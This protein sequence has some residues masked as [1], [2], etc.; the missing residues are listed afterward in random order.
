MSERRRYSLRP[1]A[2]P[3]PARGVAACV[4]ST[5][6]TTLG[7]DLQGGVQLV[8]EGEPT[9][10]QPT[11]TQEA[12]NRSL[13]IMRDRVDAFGV[14]EPEL[15]AR[16]ATRSRSTCPA[17]TNAERAAQQVGFDRAAVLLRLGS[18]HPRR[19]LQ[20]RPGRSNASEKTPITGLLQGGQAGLQVRRRRSTATTTPPT[21]RGSTRSTRSS[22]KPLNNGQPSESKE[23]GAR[24]DLTPRP[25]A[26][27]EVVEV[28][29]GILVVRDQKRERQRPGPRT[30]GG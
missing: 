17:S 20:D 27:A 8:Y 5:K 23:R 28:P 16:A 29:E 7:L 12:L 11:V 30:A 10:Q 13:D 1:A 3:R 4:I 14:A 9:A 22:K 21:R 15:R 19:G 18:E 2:R 26:N 25:S 6:K 24:R